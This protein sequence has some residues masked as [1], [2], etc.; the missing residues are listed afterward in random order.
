MLT[1]LFALFQ[2]S[3]TPLRV[4]RY[5]SF[6]VIAAMV[7]A[8]LISLYLYPRFIRFLQMKQI[9]QVIRHDGPEGHFSKR[10]TPTMGGALI[11][12]S[13]LISTLLWMDLSNLYVWVCLGVTFVLGLAGAWDDYLKIAKKNS[14]G[15]SGKGKLL[16]QFGIS[17][18]AI[19]TLLVY[20]DGFHSRLYLPFVDPDWLYIDLPIWFF[21]FF[22]GV[23]IT[24]TSNA[25]NLTD[26]LD[27]LAIGPVIV[28]T[29]TFLIL[30]Y[31]TGAVLNLPLPSE[32]GQ[33]FYEFNLAHYLNLPHLPEVSE[34]SIFCAAI[35]GAGIGFLW[36]NAY[37][38]QIFMGD[39]GSLALGGAIGMLAVC[40]RN[41]LLSIIIC[42]LFVIEALS[43]IL[44]TTSYKLRRKR[45][46]RMAPIHHH[47]EKLGWT[48]PKIVVRFWIISFT[49]SLLALASLKLR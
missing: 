8:T 14:A 45:I 38:A 20:Q 19:G 11:M 46:F 23:V 29:G 21:L 49:L 40:T 18:L 16:V 36:Y 28:A 10:G 31:V 32:L 43:V 26:G 12:F 37:P 39:T 41:E 42:G 4:V 47:F 3:F 48:E 13:M 2:A 1:W 15:L 22:S 33:G 24:G 35:I 27:G 25:V 30:A 44:Q 34:L 7:T 6:R 17:A 9:G 5:T